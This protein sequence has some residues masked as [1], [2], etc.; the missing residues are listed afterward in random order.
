MN[1]SGGISVSIPSFGVSAPDTSVSV[2][3]LKAPKVKGDTGI[4]GG[5]GFSAPE[6]S[7]EVPE[8]KEDS[9]IGGDIRLSAPEGL[10]EVPK[11]EGFSMEVPDI[12]DMEVPTFDA[13]RF[14]TGV[15]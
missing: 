7:I 14:F 4:G 6:S 11:M 15:N 13:V 8:M 3:D 1:K 2:P 12:P 9:G 5:I 10:I